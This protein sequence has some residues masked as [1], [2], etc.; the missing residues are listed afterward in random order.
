VY[1]LHI[2]LPYPVFDKRGVAKFDKAKKQLCI[3]IP[4][5]PALLPTAASSSPTDGDGEEVSL[6]QEEE[7]AVPH[8]VATKSKE[9]PTKSHGRWVEG[10]QSEVTSEESR[11]LAE[12]VRTKAQEAQRLAA[13]EA[14]RSPA[15]APAGV[16]P[17]TVPETEALAEKETEETETRRAFIPAAMF[18]G[19]K[20]GYVFKRGESGLGYHLDPYQSP[21]SVPAQPASM[22]SPPSPSSS[23]PLPPVPSPASP[24][25]APSSSF[26]FEFRQTKEAVAVILQVPGIIESTVDLRFGK[27]SFDIFF[28]AVSSSSSPASPGS[29]SGSG[30]AE[31]AQGFDLFEEV[32]VEKCKYDVA[33]QNL[34][35]LLHKAAPEYWIDK[36]PPSASGGRRR[37]VLTARPYRASQETPAAVSVPLAA[38]VGDAEGGGARE[39]RRDGSR[40]VSNIP[41]VPS[42]AELLEAMKFSTQG[43]LDLD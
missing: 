40:S 9:Q 4:V 1:D 17:S 35:V 21:V 38:A 26:L 41:P 20:A 15:R 25:A 24:K 32:L 12:E 22:P 16:P 10:K 18:V 39:E 23:A 7:K 3:T 19:R 28:K 5:Q 11:R 29:G 34:V 36:T 6:E 33:T 27:K 30:L 43:L 31:Y 42:P 13:E 2:K 14:A 8:K 37:E